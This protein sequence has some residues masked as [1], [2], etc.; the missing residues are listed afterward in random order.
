LGFSVTS[1]LVQLP[2]GFVVALSGALIPGPLFAYIV[3]KAPRAGRGVGP[4]AV[5]G[6][7]LVE[8][9]ILFLILLGLGV[10]FRWKVFQTLVGIL[11]GALLIT[12]GVVSVRRL[13]AG[14]QINRRT[15]VGY[16][17]LLGGVL[18]SS[19][20][21]PTVPLWW[22][23]IGFAMLMDAYAV[24]SALGVVCWLL[25]HYLADFGWFSLVS[26]SAAKGGRL[27]GTAGYR[28]LLLVC[29]AFLTT[30][31]VYLLAKYSGLL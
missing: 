13:R 15:F 5:I 9:A 11:G 12:L 3:A 22:A 8:A 21:N 19:I 1:A 28:R 30:L 23:T 7:A 16:A 26:L 6:H 31:G 14:L 25:G 20:L 2:I 29:A 4:K 10:V 24:G 27:L 18:Y 17:P